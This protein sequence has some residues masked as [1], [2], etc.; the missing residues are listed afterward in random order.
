MNSR[1]PLVYATLFAGAMVITFALLGIE[2]GNWSI[3]RA[4]NEFGSLFGGLGSFIALVGAVALGLLFAGLLIYAIRRPYEGN[5]TTMQAIGALL[6]GLFILTGIIGWN[7]V[8]LPDS[9]GTTLFIIMGVVGVETLV[10]RIL[11][12]SQRR[13]GSPRRTTPAAPEPTR[14]RP[15]AGS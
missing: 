7:W 12:G 4:M 10:V 15:A 8:E 3:N 1:F 14:L 5:E 13:R 6:I 9:S 11:S 2:N